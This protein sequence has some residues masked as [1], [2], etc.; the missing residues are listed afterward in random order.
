MHMFKVYNLIWLETCVPH[1]D[2]KYINNDKLLNG[3][4]KKGASMVADLV[5]NLPT[6]WE[7]WVQSLGWED[8]LE[9]GLGPHSSSPAWRIPWTEKPGWLQSMGSQRVGHNLVINTHNLS[10][11]WKF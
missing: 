3:Q 7:T 8:T 1:Q 2:N 9:K 11:K 5:K 10:R 6:M 4:S